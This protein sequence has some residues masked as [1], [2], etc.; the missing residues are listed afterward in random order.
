MFHIKQAV[1][2]GLFLKAVSKNWVIMSSPPSLGDLILVAKQ[3]TL[4]ELYSTWGKNDK[5]LDHLQALIGVTVSE[6]HTTHTPCLCLC[7]AYSAI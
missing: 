7:Y 3:T 5:Y 4:M 6:S 2:N 1:I